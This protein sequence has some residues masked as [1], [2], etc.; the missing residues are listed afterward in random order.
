[1]ILGFG[2]IEKENANQIISECS[3]ALKADSLRGIATVQEKYRAEGEKFKNMTREEAPERYSYFW[4]MC[5]EVYSGRFFVEFTIH[6]INR[7][8][9]FSP[10]G[11][12]LL[13]TKWV[14]SVDTAVW[15]NGFTDEETIF[16]PS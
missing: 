3:A 8:H 5:H 4:A 13:V 9:P 12:A 2:S 1:M 11:W 15:G 14:L 10:D 16:G 7:R 6:H